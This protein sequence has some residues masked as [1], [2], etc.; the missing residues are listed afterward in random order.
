MKD[1]LDALFVIPNSKPNFIWKIIPN[2]R[3]NHSN[4]FENQLNIV[5]KSNLDPEYA[6][7][8]IN[9]GPRLTNNRGSNTGRLSKSIKD[10]VE[11]K[12]KSMVKF[13]SIKDSTYLQPPPPRSLQHRSQWKAPNLDNRVLIRTSSETVLVLP[14]GLGANRKLMREFQCTDS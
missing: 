7:H 2:L 12:Y 5:K 10:H 4:I 13:V 14:P 11:I 3:H 6:A 8:T 9:T 1:R